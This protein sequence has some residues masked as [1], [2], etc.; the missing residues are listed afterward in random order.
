[1][2]IDVP[3]VRAGNIVTPQSR[4]AGVVGVTVS[5]NTYSFD[6][7]DDFYAADI[8]ARLGANVLSA[9]RQIDRMFSGMHYHSHPPT[10]SYATVRNVDSNGCMWSSIAAAGRGVYDWSALDTFVA[11]ASSAGRDVVFNFLGTPT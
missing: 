1:M 6:T 2:P 11:T 5:A 7:V 3:A 8:P 10:I 9:P 4:P